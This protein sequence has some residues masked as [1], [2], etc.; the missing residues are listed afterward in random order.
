ME[1]IAAGTVDVD[2]AIKEMDDAAADDD[3]M[4]QENNDLAV[5][6]F[7]REISVLKSLRHPYVI[8]M[9]YRRV[10]QSGSSSLT[11]LVCLVFIF[12]DTLCSCWP[13]RLHPTMN[14]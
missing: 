13:T 5:E 14:V 7:R 12:T 11:C 4:D 1:A 8:K 2:D 3:E 9:W 10:L 6:D